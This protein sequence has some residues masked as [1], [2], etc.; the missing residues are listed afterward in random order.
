MKQ[1]VFE[2]IKSNLETH[3]NN[4]KAHLDHIKTTED[5]SNISVKEFVALKSFAKA[6]EIDMTEICMV[7][8]YHILGM[9]ELTMTQQNTLIKL[10]KEYTSYRSDLKALT[11]ISS[12][13]KLPKLPSRSSYKLHKLGDIT[14]IS[15]LRGRTTDD[16]E[17]TVESET[18][19][20]YH[21]AKEE[22][23]A[24]EISLNSIV[25]QGNVMS[26]NIEDIDTVISVVNATAS[27]NK[28]LTAARNKTAY[29]E[30]IWEFTDGTETAIK[31]FIINANKACSIRDKLK[32]K[33]V[34]K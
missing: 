30:I 20:T 19:E 18:V 23:K 4:C 33:G 31:A 24:M 17:P 2:I 29:C 16:T 8:L 1:E 11:T 25:F 34:L 13:E 32:S 7:D 9:G 14:L 10:F 3:L 6:E 15:K 28:I 12:V 27:R 5:L 22:A 26:F 21:D